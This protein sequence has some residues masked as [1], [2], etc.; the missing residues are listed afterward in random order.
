MARSGTIRQLLLAVAMCGGVA[1]TAT[2]VYDG[3]MIRAERDAAASG[4][5]DRAAEFAGRVRLLRPVV[6]RALRAQI[7][8]AAAEDRRYPRELPLIE[9]L[10]AIEDDV[11]L[12]TRRA[13]LRAL[14][15]G[16]EALVVRDAAVTL[17]EPAAPPRP[18]ADVPLAVPPV[19][20]APAG[21]RE[22]LLLAEP[23]RDIFKRLVPP[24]PG[25]PRY[26]LMRRTAGGAVVPVGEAEAGPA[27]R[28]FDVTPDGLTAWVARPAERMLE[29][30]SLV[31]GQAES[32]GAAAAPADLAIAPG[33]GGAA[34]A[35][36]GPRS[37]DA[38]GAGRKEAL[39]VWAGGRSVR[40]YPPAGVQVGAL[41]FGWAPDGRSL[42][43]R[44]T[45]RPVPRP[46]E[47]TRLAW[48]TPDG[49]PLM[50]AVL[51]AGAGAPPPRW[52]PGPGA[53]MAIVAAGSAW[54]WD[55]KAEGAQPLAGIRGDW[56]W[57]PDGRLLAGLDVGHVFVASAAEPRK[58]MDQKL[59]GLP[60]FFALDEGGF[61]WTTDGL[62]LAGRV[63]DRE[64][65]P[66]RRATVVVKLEAKET[67]P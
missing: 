13:A 35:Y 59:E 41:R 58:R 38:A 26:M 67:A 20:P 63:A 19:A 18:P 36:A 12:A 64:Q 8:Q 61:E 53:R 54:A 39:Y 28:T 27:G 55:G 16:P 14:V 34:L 33:T 40:A 3:Y 10:L 32:F 46:G 29:R 43:V 17:G 30:W 24:G 11:G 47:L 2:L 7:A 1:V 60:P 51:D 22:P 4:Q 62:R 31:S 5:L 21:E 56:G 45:D 52:V 66:W 50:D 48:V 37:P 9:A 23:L 65:G 25:G 57:S 42:F 49:R 6:A 44:A 15:V